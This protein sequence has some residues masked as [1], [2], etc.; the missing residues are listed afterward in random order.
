MKNLSSAFT[1]VLVLAAPF[2]GVAQNN[3][4][5]LQPNERE[6][7]IPGHTSIVSAPA[8]FDPISASAE[9]L[10]YYGY[11][12]AP[13]QNTEPKAY[14]T[15]AKAMK[16][17]KTRVIPQLEQTAIMHGPMK[18]AKLANPT[19]VDSNAVLKVQPSNTANSYNWSGYA[20]F[21]G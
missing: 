7:N 3:H 4:H 10:A 20:D 9:E 18:A 21:S 6:L 19:A 8:G 17:S 5:K 15:W 11:P 16:A 12:P 14:A 2:A 13:N 1:A